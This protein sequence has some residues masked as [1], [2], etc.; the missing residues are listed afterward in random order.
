MKPAADAV[1][2]ALAR[3]AEILEVGPDGVL[4]LTRDRTGLLSAADEAGA[5]RLLD[6][7]DAAGPTPPYIVVHQDFAIPL[8]QRRYDYTDLTICL[9]SAYGGDRLPEIDHPGVRIEPLTPQWAPTV[10][11]NYTMNGPAYVRQRFADQAM[12]GA[13]RGDTLLGFIGTHVQG[14]MGL[15]FVFPEHRRQG[16]AELLVTDLGNRLLDQGFR[17]YDH[18]VVGNTASERLQRKLG[19]TVSTRR[20]CWLAADGL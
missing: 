10:I 7:L 8:V 1:L 2:D 13:F 19:F 20:L 16:V 4:L 12:Y 3:Q 11:A 17:P 15:L 6:R 18:I 5:S 14:A 9:S